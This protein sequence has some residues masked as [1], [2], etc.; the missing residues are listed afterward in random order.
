LTDNGILEFRDPFKIAR[1]IAYIEM[2]GGGWGAAP[3]RG[4]I[5]QFL[6]K[7]YFLADTFLKISYKSVHN[8]H[9]YRS[10]DGVAPQKGVWLFNPKRGHSPCLSSGNIP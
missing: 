4:E 5:F 3:R 6:P 7:T 2:G 10:M 1:D 8:C 9:K